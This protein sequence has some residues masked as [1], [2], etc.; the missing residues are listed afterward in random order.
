MVG[1]AGTG[2]TTAMRPAVAHLH[3]QGR[4]CFGAAPSAAAAE[5]L[6][7]DTGIDAD[8]LD[9][10]L[11]EHRLDRPPQ[12][13]YDLPAGTTVVV[14]EA[15]MVPTPRLAELIDLADRRGW[16][17]ALV[18]D[19]MQFSAVG[20]SGMFGQLVDTIGAVELDRV[21]RFD[22]SWEREASL[23]LRRGDTDV[24]ALYDHHDRFRGGTGR[25]M[26]KATVAAWRRATESGETAA[27]MAPTRAGVD[28]P[29]ELAQHERIAAGEIDLRSRSVKVGTSRAF[30]GDLVATRRND[31]MLLTD[32]ARMVKN[33]D[34]W[35]V[36]TSTA[37]VA[38]P[39]RV[40]PAG[41]T[42]PLTTSP[43]TSSW[44][45]PRPATPPR[46]APSTAATCSSTDP[47]AP[48]ASTS[49]SPVAAP[50]TKSS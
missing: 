30:A 41:S 31:R 45:T 49:R 22:A 50:A 27:M 24:V 11:V 29:N 48:A 35:I 47:A 15:A 9:K 7:V 5:V 37:T 21:H 32:Q 20:R 12:H 2:K 28:V 16:R 34:H 13:R 14:D 19:P 6:A 25:Q 43:L 36:E 44:P 23:R 38:S 18:G 4:P 8:T 26:A 46:A 17:L 1:P 42:Y 33:R 40:A 10:L 3:A 39:S